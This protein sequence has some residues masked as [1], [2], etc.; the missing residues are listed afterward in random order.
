LPV[1]FAGRVLRL[2]MQVEKGYNYIT[3]DDIN[4]LMD[5]YTSAVEHYNVCR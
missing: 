1:D 4:S 2:E 5:L 3:M